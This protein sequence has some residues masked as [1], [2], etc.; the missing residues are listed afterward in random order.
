MVS[1]SLRCASA[2]AMFFAATAEDSAK[3]PL[4][5]FNDSSRSFAIF[6]ANLSDASF[7]SLRADSKAETIAKPIARPIAAPTATPPII[8]PAEAPSAPPMLC[9]S[10]VPRP[11]A[12]VEDADV[13]ASLLPASA[14]PLARTCSIAFL[15]IASSIFFFI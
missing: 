6:A 15:I 2:S 5:F 1:A 8:P 7:H 3:L 10:V 4:L 13:T 12:I 14:I 9:L 11:L